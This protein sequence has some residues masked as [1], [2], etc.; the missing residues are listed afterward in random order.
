MCSLLK[1]EEIEKKCE[2]CTND[3]AIL[4]RKIHRLSRV[5]VLHLKRFLVHKSSETYEKI[6]D[7]VPFPQVIDV[8]EYL[9]PI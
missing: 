4:K 6:H 3:H 7:K 8:R 5:M 2:K 9:L 1:D